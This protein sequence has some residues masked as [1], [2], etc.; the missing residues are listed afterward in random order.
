MSVNVGEKGTVLFDDGHQG[1]SAGYDPNKFFADRRLYLTIGILVALWFVWVLGSTRLRLPASRNP[2]PREA[3]L[4]RAAGSFLSRA[5]PAHAGARQ[6]IGNF[7]HR[8][9]TRAGVSHEVLPWELLE[10]NTR[11]DPT[12]LVQLRRWSEDAEARRRVPLRPLY[13]LILRL[14]RQMAT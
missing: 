3:E 4:I 8:V 2:A 6:L 7:F 11:I 1:V 14:D 10:R 13:N 5:L 12:D 9:C